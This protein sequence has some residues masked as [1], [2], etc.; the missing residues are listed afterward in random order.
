MKTIF[1]LILYSFFISGF[2]QSY[3]GT[4]TKQVN[5][6]ERSSTTDNIIST[7]KSNTQIFIISLEKENDY[8]NI[9]VAG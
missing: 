3:L 4:I 9:M 8:Y 7:L 2:S 1:T 6:R 5:F